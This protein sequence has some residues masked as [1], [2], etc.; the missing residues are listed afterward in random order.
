[1]FA[2]FFSMFHV[3]TGDTCRLN[4]FTAFTVLIALSQVLYSFLIICKV[5]GLL[6][7]L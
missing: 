1:M 3:V 4:G 6:F 5:F 7:I 2:T